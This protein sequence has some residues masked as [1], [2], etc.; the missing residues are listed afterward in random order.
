[1]QNPV[2]LEKYQLVVKIIYTQLF[3]LTLHSVQQVNF[4]QC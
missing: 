3:I 2:F 4:L 1:M